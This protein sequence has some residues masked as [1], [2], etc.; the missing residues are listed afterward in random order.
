MNT[1]TSM[2]ALDTD[3]LRFSARSME[4]LKLFDFCC[5]LIGND[6]LGS[7]HFIGHFQLDL[8]PALFVHVH[9][10]AEHLS[11]DGARF[12]RWPGISIDKARTRAE[13]KQH[14][15]CGD[16]VRMRRARPHKQHSTEYKRKAEEE[17]THD[18]LCP[19]QRRG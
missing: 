19:R 12:G 15:D 16:R 17:P 14:S 13:G 7:C 11:V 5:R 4:M 9:T 6:Q 2:F 8:S 1:N 3:S 10:L 18:G